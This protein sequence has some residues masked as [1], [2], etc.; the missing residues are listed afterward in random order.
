MG[1]LIGALAKRAAKQ[2]GRKVEARVKNPGSKGG[3]GSTPM[4]S[5]VEAATKDYVKKRSS[6]NNGSKY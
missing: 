3:G 2:L 5:A 1:A 6:K 4:D